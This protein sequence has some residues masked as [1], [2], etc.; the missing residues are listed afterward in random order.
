MCFHLESVDLV[1]Q[2]YVIVQDAFIFLLEIF[3]LGLHLG[4]H[5]RDPIFEVSPRLLL[6]VN[7]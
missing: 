2:L 7:G 1:N 6:K 5:L 4:S 3:V